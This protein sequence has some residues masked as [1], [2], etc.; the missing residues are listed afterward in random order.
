MR[1]IASF[2]ILAIFIIAGKTT[3]ADEGL[4]LLSMIQQMNYEEM[5]QMGL[6]L[7]AEEIYNINHSSIKDGVVEFN[8]GC[9]GGIV[10]DQG[11]LL[12]AY[13]CGLDYIQY[14]SEVEDN[15][16]EDGFWAK[17]RNEELACPGLTVSFMIRMED[18]SKR[19]L[20]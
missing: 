11:L 19:V 9:T 20:S 1:R 5:Q 13:H 2:F 7:S 17:S 8:S 3:K 10:S 6:Q 4:W 12:T 18:V 16:V 14:N 15:F